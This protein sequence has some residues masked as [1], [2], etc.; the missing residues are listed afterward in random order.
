MPATYE[1]LKCEKQNK[2]GDAKYNE[3]FYFHSEWNIYVLRS[4]GI[5][6]VFLYGSAFLCYRA[7]L[8]TVP[9]EAL[10]QKWFL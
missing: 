6:K 5:R 3:A 1:M 10:N 4:T 2:R 8:K 9:G 7:W